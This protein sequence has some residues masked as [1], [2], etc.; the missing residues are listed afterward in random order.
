MI[1][2]KTDSY[3][4]VL[5]TGATYLG[6]VQH[7][8][9][10]HVHTALG[11]AKPFLTQSPKSIII[12]I[13]PLHLQAWVKRISKLILPCLEEQF[14]ALVT[15]QPYGHFQSGMTSRC[16][17]AS[18]TKR[19]SQNTR[20]I[21]QPVEQHT[22]NS[23]SSTD[24]AALESSSSCGCTILFYSQVFL[25]RELAIWFHVQLLVS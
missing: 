11:K 23:H 13:N 21:V 3:I 12:P 24:T 2:K 6:C 17:P 7:W 16:S 25:H 9:H 22:C 20:G 5:M 8:L 14:G 4:I 15:F 19:S 10:Q 1:C 18:G